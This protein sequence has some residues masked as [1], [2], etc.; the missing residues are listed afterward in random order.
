MSSQSY[1]LYMTSKHLPS[2]VY[3]INTFNH[4]ND[5]YEYMKELTTETTLLVS[6]S[7][8]TGI[9]S[10]YVIKEKPVVEE[11]AIYKSGIPIP[12]TLCHSHIGLDLPEDELLEPYLI[13]DTI[14]GDKYNTYDRKDYFSKNIESYI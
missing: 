10:D 9:Y 13:V 11:F 5:V 12:L 7:D 8:P 4:L 3:F 6:L 2:N 1:V 14:L